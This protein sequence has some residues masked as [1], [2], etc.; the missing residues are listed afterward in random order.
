M[1]GITNN[2]SYLEAIFDDFM[3][4][5]AASS[6]KHAVHMSESEG[7]D[8]PTNQVVRSLQQELVRAEASRQMAGRGLWRPGRR[9]KGIVG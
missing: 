2:V 3:A 8:P 9:I 5:V 4:T 6:S 1:K 7:G